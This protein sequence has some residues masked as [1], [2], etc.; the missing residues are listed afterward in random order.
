MT[1]LFDDSSPERPLFIS[2]LIFS[3]FLH[4]NG[5]QLGSSVRHIARN[6]LAASS[7]GEEKR[8]WT[9]G[10]SL[11]TGRSVG[12]S[13]IVWASEAMMS[14]RCLVALIAPKVESRMLGK[15]AGKSLTT[16]RSYRQ[17]SCLGVGEV[18]W[19][20]YEWQMPFQAGQYLQQA[21]AEMQARLQGSMVG[22]LT[23][24]S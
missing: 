11:Q 9:L 6:V 3:A 10:Q 18:N 21:R 20:G 7:E 1:A 4:V 22:D 2:F 19:P 5:P 14:Q 12:T 17:A 16:R 23:S 8:L 13:L 15:T 24:E